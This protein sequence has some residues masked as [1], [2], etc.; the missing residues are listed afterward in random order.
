MTVIR[1]N[2]ISGITSIT[3]QNSALNFYDSAGSKLTVDANIKASSIGVGTD[4]PDH[5]IH[6]YGAIGIGK[7]EVDGYELVLTNNNI[8]F[9]R[10]SKSYI[11][12]KGT[13]SISVRLGSSYTEV[14]EFTSNGIAF[15]SG[16]GIDFSAT[17]DGSG[18]VTSELL[19]DYEEGTF[20]PT[21]TGSTTNPTI[22][23]INQL[24]RYTKIGNVCYIEIRMVTSNVSGGSGELKIGGLPFSQSPSSN[25][26]GAFTKGF[27]YA[28]AQDPETFVT[29][30]GDSTIYIYRNDSTNTIAQVSD[31]TSGAANNYLNISGSY[32]TS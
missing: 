18:T 27:V 1:P 23:F 14:A 15:P 30:G 10:N 25:L 6:T 16:K 21:F 17:A 22:T 24:G 31:L 20:T 12:Q 3:A 26:G 7:S 4:S 32:I 8:T 5:S 13:G 29:F 2:S 11:N 19:D 9:S 28:W